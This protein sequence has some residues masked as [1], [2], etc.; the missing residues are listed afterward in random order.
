MLQSS[1][2]KHHNVNVVLISM[3]IKKNLCSYQEKKMKGGNNMG[4]YTSFIERNS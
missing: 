2:Q 3:D 4:N 1:D